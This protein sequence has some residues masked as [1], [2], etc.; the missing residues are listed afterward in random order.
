MQMLRKTIAY[1]ISCLFI[2]VPVFAADQ[3]L[4]VGDHATH[5]GY[6]SGGSADGSD[7]NN[8]YDELSSAEAAIDRS[9]YDDIYIYVGDGDYGRVTINAATD[10]TDV[11]YI[12]KATASAHGTSTGWDS[13]YGDGQAVITKSTGDEVNALTPT[14]SILTSYVTI[15]GKTRDNSDWTDTTAYGFLLDKPDDNCS[16]VQRMFLGAPMTG[17]TNYSLSNI[18]IKYMALI[19]CGDT[20]PV[21]SDILQTNSSGGAG[22]TYELAYLYLEG[23][24]NLLYPTNISNMNIH[25][26]WFDWVFNGANC[27]SQQIAPEGCDTVAVYNNVFSNGAYLTISAHNNL[28]GQNEDWD[29]YNNVILAGNPSYESGVIGGFGTGVARDADDPQ[30][31]DVAVN[32]KMHHNTFV[33]VTFAGGNAK[34][35]CPGKLNN[36]SGDQ[37]WAYN[38]LFYD[39]SNPDLSCAS[40]C[41]DCEDWNLIHDY[42]SFIDCTGTTPDETNDVTATGAGDPFTSG[43]YKPNSDAFF[44]NDGK[45]DLGSPFNVSDFYG[46]ARGAAPDI[47]AAEYDNTPVSNSGFTISGGSLQ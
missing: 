43:T 25:H 7:W 35:F 36:G 47:G 14:I 4:Y 22:T 11:I 31:E 37:S 44:L 13:T 23:G 15:D 5:A 18:T 32:W 45:T 27:H 30:A 9:T 10:S 2:A 19:G 24:Q 34:V 40:V 29:I 1:I 28:E 33:G 21:C 38:N 42:N 16:A 6:N 46:V 3:I 20:E 8:T 39:C 26:N 17:Y 41:D 12:Y